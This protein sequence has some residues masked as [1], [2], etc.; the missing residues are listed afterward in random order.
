MAVRERPPPPSHASVTAPT[1]G[2]YALL[3]VWSR[4]EQ[5]AAL[6]LPRKNGRAPPPRLTSTQRK[7]V[8][9]LLE[10]HGDNLHV[11]QGEGEEGNLVLTVFAA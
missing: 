9:G 8:G 2:P 5:R 4:A 10:K 1:L 7:V 3:P 11:R 6:H